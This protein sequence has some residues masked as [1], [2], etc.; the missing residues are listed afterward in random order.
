MV[1]FAALAFFVVVFVIAV[2]GFVAFAFVVVFVVGVFGLVFATVVSVVDS[3][4][5]GLVVVCSGFVACFGL[6]Q[7]CQKVFGSLLMD[8]PGRVS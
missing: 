1:V 6:V 5:V 7:N 4:L 8:T 3:V 2:F